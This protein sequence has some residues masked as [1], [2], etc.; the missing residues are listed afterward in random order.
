MIELAELLCRHDDKGELLVMG[1]V[2]RLL[3][4]PS[5]PLS[6]APIVTV[7]LDS[8]PLFPLLTALCRSLCNGGRWR[9]QIDFDAI[10]KRANGLTPANLF[11]PLP[12]GTPFIEWVVHQAIACIGINDHFANA[13]KPVI[14]KERRL[15]QEQMEC[16]QRVVRN[17]EEQI[18]RLMKGIDAS[19][20]APLYAEDAT[21]LQ[22]LLEGASDASNR[23]AP[24]I[25]D[26][27]TPMA[28]KTCINDF[29]VCLT[30]LGRV[31]LAMH[32]GT[33]ELRGAPKRARSP[34]YGK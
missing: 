17:I 32:M 11:E 31:C 23:V 10:E 15:R 12:C 27:A 26:E 7:P 24:F 33:Y 34:T 2:S 16:N 20:N 30:F 9:T 19:A 18:G 14:D 25:L 5:S 1:I 13:A 21:M 22:A 6:D 3:A 29:Q 8:E 28:L 4:S